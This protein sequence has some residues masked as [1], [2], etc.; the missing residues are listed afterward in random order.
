[1]FRGIQLLEET[2]PRCRRHEISKFTSLKCKCFERKPNARKMAT[3]N[4]NPVRE[5]G[6]CFANC[7]RN[8]GSCEPTREY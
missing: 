3:A 6:K 2:F 4:T 7:N 5:K 8:E 1:M